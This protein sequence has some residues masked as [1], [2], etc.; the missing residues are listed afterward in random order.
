[1]N[2][3]FDLLT[4]TGAITTACIVL[5]VLILVSTHVFN[6]NADEDRHKH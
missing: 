6:S 5:I 3:Y 2:I 1:M 4:L